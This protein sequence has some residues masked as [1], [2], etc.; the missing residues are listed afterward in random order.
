ML[1]LNM[2]VLDNVASALEHAPLG[3]FHE[4]RGTLAND[5]TSGDEEAQRAPVFHLHNLECAGGLWE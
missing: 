2:N 5:Y 3:M 4:E 1:P